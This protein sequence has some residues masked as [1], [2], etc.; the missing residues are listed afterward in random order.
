MHQATVYNEEEMVQNLAI[1]RKCLAPWYS[2]LSTEFL[3]KYIDLSKYPLATSQIA[4]IEELVDNQNATQHTIECWVDESGKPHIIALSDTTIVHHPNSHCYQ[5]YVPS[6]KPQKIVDAIEDYVLN[7]VP[8][9]KLK[10]TCFNV[11]VWC[12][13]G[14]YKDIQTIEINGRI[15]FVYENMY[16]HVYGQSV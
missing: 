4:M 2:L 5:Y 6:T 11:E 15:A 8:K 7:L 1:L 14:G 10:R 16:L 13:E 9:F 12:R 3:G